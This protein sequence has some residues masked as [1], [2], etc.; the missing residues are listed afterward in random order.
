MNGDS[1]D[2]AGFAQRIY[3]APEVSAACLRLQDEY[4]VDVVLLLWALWRGATGRGP[5]P[6]LEAEALVGPW[7]DAVVQPLRSVRRA[8]KSDDWPVDPTRRLAV[9]TALQ[10][11]EIEA[12]LLALDALGRDAA[13]RAPSFDDA[14]HGMAEV[15]ALGAGRAPDAKARALFTPLLS[16]AGRPSPPPPPNG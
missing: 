14:Q 5:K 10:R 7:R 2:L 12:E 4:G 6:A 16:A 8:M 15:F 9:R 11:L 1:E 3:A 13:D